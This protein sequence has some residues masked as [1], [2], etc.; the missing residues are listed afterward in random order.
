MNKMYFPMAMPALVLA[1]NFVSSAQII[2]TPLPSTWV[3]LD[4]VLKI[5][6]ISGSSGSS[7]GKTST[8]QAVSS[9]ET[10]IQSSQNISPSG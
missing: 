8:M 3:H 9:Y 4:T 10:D 1:F 6:R 7:T 2:D 5:W